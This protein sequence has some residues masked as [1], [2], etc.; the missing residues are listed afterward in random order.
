[1]TFIRTEHRRHKTAAGH[2]RSFRVFILMCDNCGREFES[3]NSRSNIEHATV[4]VCSPECKSAA[5]KPGGVI[6]RVRAKT[7][8]EKYGAENVYASEHALEKKRITSKEHFGVEHHMQSPAF[9]KSF[10]ESFSETHDGVDW[11]SKTESAVQ[12][13]IDAWATGKHVSNPKKTHETMLD[14]YGKKA[15]TNYAKRRLTML[16]RY[17]VEQVVKEDTV[18]KRHETMKKNNSYGRSK[19]ETTLYEILCSCFGGGNVERFV[20]IN[21]WSIDIRVNVGDERIYVQFDG[22]YY[23]ALG[24]SLAELHRD[25]ALFGRRKVILSTVYRDIAQRQWFDE[26][27]LKLVRIGEDVFNDALAKNDIGSIISLVHADA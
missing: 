17:K 16:E 6:E 23:H 4:H 20:R 21:G 2:E 10:R 22:I 3:R 25:A 18:K 26:H 15:L 8:K 1:M 12:A 13:M 19:P 24:S 9:V 11:P 5:H 7:N 14:R 27:E